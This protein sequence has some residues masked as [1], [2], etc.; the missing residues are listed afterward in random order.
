MTR[1]A[2]ET[3]RVLMEA[4]HYRYHPLAQRVQDILASGV[5]GTIRAL[6]ADFFI[7]L[8]FRRNDIRFDFALAGGAMMDTGC[9]CM[10]LLR[11]LGGEPRV[12]AAKA[13]LSSP[14]VDR[15]MHAEMAFENGVSGQLNCSLAGYPPVKIYARVVGDEGELDILNPF[16]PQVYHWLR[17]KT[18][19][20]TR[21]ELVTREPTYNFQLRA[22]VA[23]TRG[24]KTN[25]TDGQDGIKN[26]RVID[27]V[28]EKAGLDPRGAART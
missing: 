19:T 17:I 1:V 14:Q 10:N 2:D 12:I 21:N 23:A 3:G 22:F 16:V 18:K 27:A 11:W 24:E 15:V 6:Q 7:P 8:F 28:Y 13:V 20:G 25:I 4:F 5:L 9:Y 26:M